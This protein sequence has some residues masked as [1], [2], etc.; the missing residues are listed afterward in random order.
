MGLLRSGAASPA[1]VGAGIAAGGRRGCLRP[2]AATAT[3]CSWVEI[4]TAPR[5]SGHAVGAHRAASSDPS[6]A[7]DVAAGAAEQ[8]SARLWVGA[9][10]RVIGREGDGRNGVVWRDRV[11]RN[12][13][14]RVLLLLRE[15]R[16]RPRGAEVR[17]CLR[18]GLW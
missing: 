7:S 3:S 1:F 13:Y 6:T 8:P 10:R 14:R 4:V 9:G 12:V 2:T 5:Q 11:S 18:V 17:S 15:G 16:V